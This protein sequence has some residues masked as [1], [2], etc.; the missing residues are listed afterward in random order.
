M[1]AGGRY[2]CSQNLL[3]EAAA[4]KTK[5]RRGTRA[6]TK[7]EEGGEIWRKKIEKGL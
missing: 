2:C 7:F 1:L 5:K 4:W 3:P 6:E